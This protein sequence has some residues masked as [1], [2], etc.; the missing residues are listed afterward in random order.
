MMLKIINTVKRGVAKLSW[1]GVRST[2]IGFLQKKRQVRSP[3][4][5]LD[6]SRRETLSRTFVRG[7]RATNLVW[8]SD[9]FPIWPSVAVAGTGAN[10]PRG[11]DSLFRRGP[12][13]RMICEKG[14]SRLLA[15]LTK[16]H[17]QGFKHQPEL[18]QARVVRS[19]RNQNVIYKQWF[20]SLLDREFAGNFIAPALLKTCRCN[21]TND[22]FKQGL[23]QNHN[24]EK[25]TSSSTRLG[26][27][28]FPGLHSH[29]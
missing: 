27:P 16:P 18:R 19:I 29:R 13:P 9:E 12:R 7:D 14:E 1:N 17:S 2:E 23:D 8:E 25:C 6:P 3:L 5:P 21:Q 11:M 24:S 4:L 20:M 28:L 26:R 10:L 15:S 22:G